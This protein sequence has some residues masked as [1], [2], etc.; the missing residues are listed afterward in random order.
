M[1]KGLI[2]NECAGQNPLMKLATHFTASADSK[3]LSQ[4][5]MS[6]QQQQQQPPSQLF[7]PDMLVAEYLSLDSKQAA[8]VAH[9][10]HQHQQHHRPQQLAPRSFHME[11]LFKELKQIEN[12][13]SVGSG[14]VMA[15]TTGASAS[16]NPLNKVIG[17]GLNSTNAP[18]STTS[19]DSMAN[20]WSQEYWSSLPVSASQKSSVATSGGKIGASLP[21]VIMDSNAFKWS[22]DYLSQNE[23]TIFDE[24]W[25]NLFFK[26]NLNTV[27]GANLSS[28]ATNSKS[29]VTL[30]ES[31]NKLNEEMMK[32][33]NE[34]LDSMQD[35]RFSETEVNQFYLTLK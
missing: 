29:D 15:Q 1:I 34:L 5:V 35:S 25:E 33:A 14:A 4:S 31:N 13:G 28:M 9:H 12:S 19:A 18:A 7:N 24:A 3:L 22:A 17:S 26:N 30:A 20:D 10:H 32:T 21:P 16:A 11:T 6:Q 8:R 23:S 27:N 2:E